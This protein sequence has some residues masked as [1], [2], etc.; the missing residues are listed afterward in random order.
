[1]NISVKSEYALHAIFDLS[2]QPQ[3]EPVKIA[4]ISRRLKIPKNSSN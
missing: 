4:E 1:V 3:G 2:V